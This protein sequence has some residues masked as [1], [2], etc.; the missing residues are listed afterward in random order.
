MIIGGFLT[1]RPAIRLTT[2]EKE[3]IRHMNIVETFS[4]SEFEEQA[5][6]SSATVIGVILLVAGTIIWAY[7]GVIAI[8]F[9]SLAMDKTHDGKRT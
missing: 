4:P 5:R 8:V 1:Y 9:P 3:R 2:E 6:D 7:G